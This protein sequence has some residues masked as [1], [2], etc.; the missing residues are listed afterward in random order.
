VARRLPYGDGDWFAV[1]LRSDGFGVG[2]VSCH[3]GHGGVVGY[4]MGR[5]FDDVPAIEAVERFT[6]ADSLRVVRFGDLGLVRAMWPVI[7][8]SRSWNATDWPL[9]AFARR[10]AS[11]EC[12]RVEY[13]PHDLAGPSREIEVGE[14]ECNRLPRDALS[15]SGAV[16]KILT[17]LLDTNE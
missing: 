2:I 8:R 13:E 6:R 10:D 5:R 7:G 12:Y 17:A 14:D 4:L 1:P 15:G 11:G 3:D 16:E 9:P